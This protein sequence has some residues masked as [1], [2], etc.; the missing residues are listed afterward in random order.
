[1]RELIWCTGASARSR[2]GKVHA[3]RLNGI[4]ESG[5]RSAC[6]SRALAACA[7][8]SSAQSEWFGKNKVQYKQ[9]E[10]YVLKTPHF[11]I[12]FPGG[13]RDLAARTGVILES[14]YSKLSNDLFASDPLA[15]SGHHLREPRRF[16]A[17]ERDLESH[18]RGGAGVRGA[19]AEAHGASFRRLERRIR[20]HRRARARSHFQLRYHLRN[21]PQVGFLAEL[22]LSDSAVVHGGDRG[23]LFVRVRSK[24]RDVHAR[25]DGLRLYERSRLYRRLH[26]VQVGAGGDLLSERDVRTGQGHRDHGQPSHHARLA[27]FG[28][29]DVAGAH[30]RGVEPRLEEGDAEALLASLRGQEGARGV[31]QAAHRSHEESSRHEY[32]AGVFA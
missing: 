3:V 14:G 29:A 30:L 25:R 18:S 15:H 6:L 10:W 4:V 17:D 23:I 28:A 7:A 26:G 31:R 21:A 5:T 12:N 9:F 1:M 24:R 8:P 13:Y 22:S 32:Q 20:A 27:R 11:D 19:D 2:R 16:P